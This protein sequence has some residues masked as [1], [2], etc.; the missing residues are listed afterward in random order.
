M[1]E[2]YKV[3]GMGRFIS[4]R[5]RASYKVS[6]I[7]T[8]RRKHFVDRKFEIKIIRREHFVG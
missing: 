2:D 4:L 6:V 1:R 7:K 3:F 8:T 5:I